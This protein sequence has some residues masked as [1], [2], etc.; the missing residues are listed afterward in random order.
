MLKKILK[1]V[2]GFSSGGS[3]A[4]DV[5]LSFYGGVGRVTGA[6]FVLR[7][8]VGNIMVDCGLVQGDEDAHFVNQADFMYN[9]ASIDVL[10][11]THA[12]ADHIGRIPK[13]VRDGFRGVIYSTDAT[14]DLAEIMLE[15]AHGLMTSWA[16]KNDQ[17]PWYSEQ[18]LR[19][20]F[21][22]W[23][24]IPYHTD[25]QIVEGV[26]VHLYDAGHVL[27][28]AIMKLSYREKTIVF[29]GDLGNSP[30]PLLRDTEM[31]DQ[32]DYVVMESV[33]GDRNHEEVQ[34]RKSKLQKAIQD[35]V[36]KGGVLMIPAFSLER[37]QELLFEINDLVENNKVP[38]VPIF[39]DSPLAIAATNIY[40]RYK[41]YFN[42]NAKAIIAA[43]DDIFSF[44]GLKMTDSSE[45]S[46]GI[47]AVP[48]PKIVIAGSGMSHGGRILH[49][50][51]RYLPDPKSMLLLVGYQSVGTLGR[52]LQQKPSSVTIHNHKVKV[53][54]TISTIH[55]YSGH[56]DSDH[57]LEFVEKMGES[58]NTVFCVMGET[59]SAA[60]LAQR[61]RD[62]LGIKAVHPKVGQTIPLKW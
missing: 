54:A 20:A 3:K 25:T 14:R 9:P 59:K 28:S 47:N 4:S 57:L 51:K 5:S 44:P 17:E 29:T 35:T 30:M 58:I 24:T 49:H 19:Q 32:A 23:Q 40:S 6:N 22:Q 2:P 36:G 52:E 53:R 55:G 48:A 37:T 61:I 15:N 41:D 11:V 21:S 46:R 10:L 8:P 43:G 34:E 42:D 31:L 12:H 45:Q 1:S 27:G 7:L 33:Y 13:L 56:R 16:A 50:E 18:D 62:Y 26:N 39:L 60:F 38:R